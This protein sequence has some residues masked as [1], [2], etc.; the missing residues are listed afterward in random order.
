M[1]DNLL[2]WAIKTGIRYFSAAMTTDTDVPQDFVNI[3]YHMF[4]SGKEIVLGLP[5]A[6]RKE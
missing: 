2:K 4:S 6:C 1:G 5:N 3:I